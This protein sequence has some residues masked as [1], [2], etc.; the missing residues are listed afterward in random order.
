[1]SSIECRLQ[2]LESESAQLRKSVSKYR[3]VTVVMAVLLVAGV[4][5][6]QTPKSAE[7]A[8]VTC[9]ALRVATKFE[10]SPSVTLTS[11]RLLLQTYEGKKLVSLGVSDRG[12]GGF[13]VVGNKT[14][15]E[16]VQLYA[17]DYGNG[18]VGAWNRKGKGRTL[19]PG[20]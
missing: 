18:V 20:P 12:N 6:G 11:G 9:S 17:D 13:L 3:R 19:K 14:G 5:M 8:M 7:F 1:M 4:T 16:V 15:E 2:K 10:G